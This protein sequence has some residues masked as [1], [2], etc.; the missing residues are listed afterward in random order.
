MIKKILSYLY[1]GCLGLALFGCSETT[2]YE[3][4][5]SV[6][7][8]LDVRGV[9]QYS[10]ALNGTSFEVGDELGI[11]VVDE[12]DKTYEG[13]NFSNVKYTS[14]MQD[15]DMVWSA[16]D[17]VML[18]G[19]DAT[20]YAYYPY[21][22]D[23]DIENIEVDMSSQTD[24]LYAEPVSG[25]NNTN[26][27][28]KIV[29][30]HALAN[31]RFTVVKGSYVGDG[32]VSKVTV[33]SGV[34][35]DAGILNAKTGLI[36][37]DQTA[38]N[39]VSVNTD[40]TLSNT[41]QQVDIHV[42]PNEGETPVE[43][44]VTVDGKKYSVTSE[45]TGINK[46]NSYN[47]NVTHNSEGLVLT[48]IGVNKWVDNTKD[49]LAMGKPLSWNNIQN[50]VY[51]VNQL[52][53][54]VTKNSADPSCIAVALVS[55]NQRIWIEKNGELNTVSIKEAYDA[56][57]ATVKTYQFFYWGPLD[58]DVADI[59][60]ID[61]EEDA[62]NDFAGKQHTAHILA[63]PDNDTYTA[64][65]NMGTWC[66]KFNANQNEN[67]GYADWYIPSI[68]QLIEIY[69]NIDEIDAM[70]TAIGGKPLASE[71]D[72]WSSTE[73]GSNLG[74]YINFQDYEVY[75]TSKSTFDRVRFVRDQTGN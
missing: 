34:I 51:A 67:F 55:D 46:G 48:S 35:A 28:S 69:N 9:E 72:Y 13:K 57:A 22:P 41:A 7:L 65:A 5:V 3:N 75:H 52:G 19:K 2:D 21:N 30:H 68:G 66:S 20:L 14:S 43:I 27:V 26:P 18:S 4:T 60:N 64:F 17:G 70:L 50:G 47:F 54:P 73:A 32:K 25:L 59:A 1:T 10:R 42:I 11:C 12:S 49:E 24:W 63:T 38:T 37:V 36:T 15:G 53:K 44:E 61:T 16:T 8:Q 39:S 40:L 71:E 33:K 45:S 31:I 58:K 29:L 74:W 56:D 23:I 62:A 6:P